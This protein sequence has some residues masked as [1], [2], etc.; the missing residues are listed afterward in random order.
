M[1]FYY[2]IKTYTSCALQHKDLKNTAPT[3]SWAMLRILKR[4]EKKNC[5]SWLRIYLESNK[6]ARYWNCFPEPYF[7]F[8]MFIKG[9]GNL[10]LM[11]T[12]IPQ[13]AYYKYSKDKDS[14]YQVL[15]DDKILF[16]EIMQK[17]NLPV[18]DRFFVFQNNVFRR[19]GHRITDQEVDG[20]ISSI[21][22]SRI[23][24]KKYMGGAGS[25][26]TVAVRKDNGFYTIEGVRLSATM[27]RD[28][29]Q[30]SNYIFEKQI[31]QEKILNQFNPDTVNTI[32]I[33]TY[34]N[35]PISAAIR[36]GGKGDFCDN[37]SKGGVAVNIDLET[38]E[39]GEYGMR[40][41][42]IKKYYVHPDSHIAFHGVSVPKWRTVLDVVY[43]T[44]EVMPYY[45]SV[46]F[47]IAVT[48]NGPVI[49]EINTGAGINLSQMGK[50][51]GLAEFFL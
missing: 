44:L 25:G 28:T 46:G 39:L 48:D 24:I 22:D 15:I 14:R 20:I 49:I 7:R 19:E 26:V 30:D 8:G 35:K 21:N 33:L 40:M 18:P 17:N 1:L 9:F 29:Y 47:D 12:F 45:N 41:Y 37:I 6:L 4:S 43:K 16:H 51:K 38:G 27:I 50:K 42:D 3:K 2:V 34:K 31:I 10:E 5:K 11:K 23:F 32:R 36:F 13:G